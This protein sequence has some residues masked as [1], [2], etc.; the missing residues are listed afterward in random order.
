MTAREF[1]AQATGEASTEALANLTNYV[2]NGPYDHGI[3]YAAFPDADVSDL[4]ADGEEPA[5][6][7]EYLARR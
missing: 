3:D 1:V 6:F 5:A 7:Q 4:A 2:A